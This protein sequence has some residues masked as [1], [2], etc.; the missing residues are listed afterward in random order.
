[1]AIKYEPSADWPAYSRQ[2]LFW[3]WLTWIFNF[4]DRGLIG[5][6]LPLMIPFFHLSLTAAGGLVS[7]FFVGY[8]STFFG[9]F[10]S[11]KVGRKKVIGPSVL[12]FGTVTG[13]TALANSVPFLAG[14]RILTGVFE[15]FQYPTGAAWVSETYPYSRRA[16]ALAFWETGYSIGTLLGIVLAT[17]I[18]AHWGWRAP[19]PIS[20][21]LSIIAGILLIVFVKERPRQHSPGY[22]EA[23]V[24]SSG[25]APHLSEVWK[26]RNVW[27]V[28]I[29]HG[30]YNFTFWM[31]G[32]W[33]PLYVIHVRHLSFVGGG[34]LSGVLF[35]GITI[36]L[37][38]SGFVADKI[39]RVRAISYMSFV[40]A[41][42]L[43]IFTQTSSPLGL[44]L[45]IALGGIFGAYIPTAIALVTDTTNPLVSGTA[46]GIALF[47]AELG[48]VL[49]PVTGGFIAQHFGLQT[50][51]YFLPASILV[52]AMLVWLAEDP[53]SKLTIS[54]SPEDIIE[55]G[56]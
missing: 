16:K 32:A 7:L 37:V 36:G 41:I 13:I 1:M 33:I 24:L 48:A 21:L 53:R 23:M 5:P 11:D 19:W 34:L 44:F 55:S 39:G 6:L 45:L 9:G 3:N 26:K 47:G 43:F 20:G 28:F 54:Q 35:G 52:A 31:A 46:F 42:L 27:V 51:M 12:G 40:S 15:G 25:Q 38:V 49:G 17:L 50:A 8:L 4:I 2:V 29:L 56:T 10:I 30:L 22:Q 14:I 18:A